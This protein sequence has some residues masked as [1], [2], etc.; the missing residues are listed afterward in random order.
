VALTTAGAG[1]VVRLK[2]NQDRRLRGGHPWIF[3]NEIEAF[4][5]AVK[6][7][8]VVAIEDARG[9]FL[10]QGYLNRHSL[11]AVR[12]LT[13]GRE[14]ID[15]AFFR[16]RLKRA[17]AYREGMYPGDDAIRLVSAE[18]DLLPGLVVDRYG[19]ALAVGISTLGMEARRDLVL[20]LLEQELS[21]R[22]VILRA[23]SPLRALEGLPLER[24]HWSGEEGLEPVV[25]M[26]GLRYRVDPLGGQ[27]TG[28]FLDQRDNRARLAG[29]VGGGRVLDAF[30]Y[31]G[32]WGLAALGHGAREAVFIDS[33][34]PALVAAEENARLNE[35][36][37]RCQFLKDDAFDGLAVLGR[38][39]D[40]FE[41]VVLDPP[42]LVKSRA[43]KK[44]GLR[45]YLELN[46]RAMALV[47]E[48]GWLFASSC[49]HAVTEEEFRGVLM[50]AGQVAHRQ[51]RLVEWGMQAKDHP[52]LLAAPETGY[53]KCAVLQG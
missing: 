37:G 43:H 52:V 42:A 3:S 32:A 27:K 19:P 28:L 47:A 1:A 53:L 20:G 12:V 39:H 21:P 9:A 13:R 4:S 46:R 36:S 26:G 17:F 14:A 44:E 25:T 35:M 40:R 49:S 51:F 7:G 18:G 10:G 41:V 6:D 33:S 2:K 23:D 16:K 11:I 8:D 48:G 22:S 31:N 29:R 50:R 30:C 38:A 24:R 34:E 5:G 15:E 45:A